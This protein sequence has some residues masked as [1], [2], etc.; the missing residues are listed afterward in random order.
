M[1]KIYLL[2]TEHFEKCLWFRGQE[3]F[4]V[5]M[6]Y[7]AVQAA[8]NRR[9]VVLAFIL[10]SNHVHFVL[11]C[12]YA[13]A[14]RFIDEFKKHH[15]RYLRLKYGIR[16]AL[17]G[18]KSD[19]RPIEGGGE[20]MENVIA[21]V[22]MNPVAANIC[23]HPSAYRWGTGRSFFQVSPPKAVR[24]GT[25]SINAARRLLHSKQSLPSD[26]L[27][28]EDGYILPESYV[29]VKLVESIFKT[30]RRMNYYLQ[31]SS[32][33]KRRREL[34]E[35][36]LPSFRDQVLY[37]AIP[38]L[39][40]SLF[41]KNDASDLE[42]GQRQELVRQIRRRFSADIHQIVRVTSFSMEDVARYLD[43]P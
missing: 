40:R 35:N 32:K 42:Y 17:K 20:S 28:G 23:L 15:S 3:D 22:Q 39:C 43:A 8:S 26:W 18:N 24:L 1:K 41:G 4:K 19:I 25:L 38:D 36:E 12:S 21:Y 13:Q 29:P 10:M 33:A 14:R 34:Q 30:P 16:E 37:A 5:A 31:N 7:V 27:V 9:V 6:N 2:T 11:R